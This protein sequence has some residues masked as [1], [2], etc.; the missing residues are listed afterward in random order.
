LT[1]AQGTQAAV[2]YKQVKIMALASKKYERIFSKTGSDADKIST[3]AFDEIKEDF[4]QNRYL[5]DAG[6]FSML[7]PIL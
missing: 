5:E 6:Q 1:G 3:E 7:G 4:D 2:L